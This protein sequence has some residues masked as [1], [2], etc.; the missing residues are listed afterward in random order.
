MSNPPVNTQGSPAAAAAAVP[1]TTAVTE[2]RH[3]SPTFW[4]LNIIEMW[5]R[6]AYYV[7]RP[8][9][10]I[11][12]MQA[13][14]PG[15]LHLTAA[16]KGTIYAWWAIF[17]SLLP[18]VTGGFADRYGYKRTLFFSFTL[19]IAGYLMMAFFPSYWGFF[20]GIIVLATGTA[21]FKPALQGTLAHTLNKASASLGWGIFYWI[22][23]V[24]SVVGHFLSPLLLGNPHSAAGWRNLFLACAGF[25]ALNYL[26]LFTFK[27]VPSGASKTENPLQVLRRT[28]VNVFEPRLIAWL[29]IMSCF[30]LMMYQ[31]WDTQPNFIEDWVNSAAIAQHMPFDS[32]RETGDQGLLRVPQ[33]VLISLNAMLIVI[34]VVPVSWLVR[35]MRTLSAMFFGMVMATAGLLVA[36]LT[37]H[38]AILLVGIGLFSLGEML[39][40]PKKSEYLALIAPPAK[41][42]LYLGYVN[43]PV[44]IGVA[45]GNWI[46]GYVYGHYGEKA[47]LALK[48]LVTQTSFGAGKVWDGSLAT[49]ETVAGI[50]RTDAFATLQQ[51]LGLDGQ[52]ATALLWDTYNPQYIWFPFAAIGVVAAIALAIF[53]QLAKRWRDMNA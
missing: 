1:A 25:T 38:G 33:Q 22:V 21:F 15:G 7:L 47:T 11:Y 26:M 52:Q 36:G 19:N 6:L 30:W 3:F 8:V 24:G 42:G 39:T 29:L 41:K 16:H 44:G 13:T 20:G 35:R 37:P 12:I 50:P 18:M 10:P 23:N 32:W 43:I 2:R 14:E 5:E 9:A 51:V 17:Q 27:D 28:I 31:L 40:G 49:L 4:M 45:A 46:A 53:G 48:Y 34:F